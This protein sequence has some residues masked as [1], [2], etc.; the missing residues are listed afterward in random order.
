[1]QMFD[2]ATSVRLI[3]SQCKS[4]AFI[5]SKFINT[6]STLYYTFTEFIIF[7]YTFQQILLINANNILF[8]GFAMEL[9]F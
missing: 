7:L 8:E 1:M 6:V 9:I 5:S 2:R 4:D 3:N